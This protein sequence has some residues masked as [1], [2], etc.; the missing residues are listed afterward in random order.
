MASY[1]TYLI[2]SLPMLHFGAK[3][4]LN[5][6]DFSARCAELIADKDY[7][8][9]RRAVSTDGF[10]LTGSLPEALLRWKNFDLGLRNELAKVR[11]LRRKIDAAK[12]LRSATVFDMRLAH[13]AQAALRQTN[14]LEAEKYLDFA[15]WQELEEIASGHYFD[16]EFLLVY[17]LKLSILERQANIS[18]GQAGWVDTLLKH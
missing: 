9:I 18:L 17:A 4:A 3:P 5:L 13:I 15:R 8:F 2:A 7:Q 12:F 14:I 16:L 1:Y 6:K 11:S 10:A